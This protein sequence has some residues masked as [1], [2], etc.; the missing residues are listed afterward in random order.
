VHYQHTAH[1]AGGAPGAR[2]SL[3]PLIS[4]GATLTAK[5]AWMRGEIAKLRLANECP[6]STWLFDN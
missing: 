4:E 5:L 2:H 3:R 1:E 6:R